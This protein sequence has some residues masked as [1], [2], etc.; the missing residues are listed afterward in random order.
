MYQIRPVTVTVKG[1]EFIRDVVDHPG[2]VCVLALTP[3]DRIIF[4]RQYRCG[5]EQSTLELP[6]GRLRPGELPEEAARREMEAETGMRPR[7]LQ[8]VGRFYP[9]P[10]YSSE[11]VSCF[12]SQRLEPGSMRFDESE[13]LQV[14][15]LPYADAM[16]AVRCGEITD[17]RSIVALLRWG[18]QIYGGL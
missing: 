10:G 4:V 14:L 9:A 13:D 5:I 12:L 6:G 11:E 8:L 18:D 1:R 15:F 3:E 17:A 16:A 7:D 2:S